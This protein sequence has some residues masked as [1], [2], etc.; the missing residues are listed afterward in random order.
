VECTEN[1]NNILKIQY[2][3]FV[4]GSILRFQH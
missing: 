2:H 1:R 3:L 4:L